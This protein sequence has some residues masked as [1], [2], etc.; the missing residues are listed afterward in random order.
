M[1]SRSA[2]RAPAASKPAPFALNGHAASS[3]ATDRF[4]TFAAYALVAALLIAL[5]IMII[6]PHKIGDYMAETDFYGAY[7][8]GAHLVQQGRLLPSRYG[9]IG[10]GYE[11]MLGLLGFVIRDLFFAA[12]LLSAL[13]TVAVVLL[14]F[15][16][17]RARV[18][19][20]LG[21]FTV[22]FMVTNGTL[23]RHGYGALTD[24]PAIALQAGALFLLLVGQ[25]ERSLGGAGLL[26][27][28]AFL[29]RYNSIVLLPAGLVAI[30]AGGTPTPH[31]R[32][33]A[34]LF[35]AGFLAP[36]FP[37][38]LYSLAHGAS[39]SFQLHH[40]IAY[41]VFA[42]A[43]GIPW[44]DYQRDLQPQ[45]HSLWDVIARDPRAVASRMLW[46][47]FDHVRQDASRLLGWPT[48]AAAVIGLALA[49]RDGT[50]RRLWPLGVAGI[51][52]FMTLVPVFYSE[53]YSLALL[54]YYAT[55]A[56]AA[57]ASPLLAFALGRRRRIWLK[58]LAA[59]IP[60]VSAV[61]MNVKVQAR[62]LDQLPVEVLECAETLR[63]LRAPGDRVIARKWHIAYHGGVEAVGFPFTKTLPELARYAREAKAR[64]L[65]FS[66]PE[67]ETR[68]FYAYLLD[69]SA[70]VPGLTARRV[71][72]PHPAVLYEIGPELGRTPAWFA[73]DTLKAWHETYA[74]LLVD[75][76]DSQLLYRLGG[77]AFMMGRYDRAREALEASLQ[78]DPRNFEAL[79]LLG[80][81]MVMTNDAPAAEALFRRVEA[82]RPDEP[83]ARVGLGW[84]SLLTGDM[85]QAAA[86]WRPV[87]TATTNPGTLQRMVDLFRAVGD[88][89]A[90][91]LAMATL[92]RT[93]GAP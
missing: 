13:A 33:A 24:A 62:V 42:R 69:T 48:A 5:L 58:P 55:L 44:D 20:R 21:F 31:R 9:V 87:I 74:R 73:N 37:W 29:T 66:W 70:I 28:L 85:R 47:V 35:T 75:G 67:L 15:H 86:L 32:R 16:M 45:F 57:F 61:S 72:H 1:K 17:L 40:N 19:A 56:G 84:V 90:A 8:Q 26:A 92:Q 71:T 64:W 6:G 79:L 27:A 91:A 30:L 93:R 59:I 39:F 25:R 22:L 23:F 54:P 14:W 38:V 63:Q 53:R 34:L 81:I 89:E 49:W 65:Y 36:V 50:L 4:L 82:I 60:L 80:N 2:R 88:D 10:P 46:N 77:I 83:R 43:R 12:E 7:A 41:E 76:S 18:G 78:R 51:L 3:A 11:V 52:L 68:P